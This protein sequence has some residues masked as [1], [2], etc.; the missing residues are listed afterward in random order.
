MTQ[1]P[2]LLFWDDVDQDWIADVPDVRYCS[3]HGPTPEDALREVR[4]ALSNI[5]ADARERGI[6]L[7]PPTARPV[8]AQAS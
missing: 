6:E 2:I 7:P 1:Y 3:A 8:L 5:L 4:L